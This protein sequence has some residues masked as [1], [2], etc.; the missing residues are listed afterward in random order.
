MALSQVDGIRRCL[1]AVTR[2]KEAYKDRMAEMKPFRDKEMECQRKFTELMLSLGEGRDDRL[3]T[4]G[5][6]MPQIVEASIAKG[7]VQELALLLSEYVSAM[8]ETHRID[9]SLLFVTMDCSEA[10]LFADVMNRANIMEDRAAIDPG[11]YL[12]ALMLKWVAQEWKRNGLKL[13]LEKATHSIAK[14]RN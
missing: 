2:L 12:M 14:E 4:A 3:V 13:A 7:R 5:E 6:M 8:T 9:Q 11:G 10:E 1:E